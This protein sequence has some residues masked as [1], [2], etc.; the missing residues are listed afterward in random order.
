MRGVDVYTANAEN[1]SIMSSLSTCRQ[2]DVEKQC[3]M[4]KQRRGVYDSQSITS[5]LFS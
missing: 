3:G 1:D 5:G 2:M 4:T